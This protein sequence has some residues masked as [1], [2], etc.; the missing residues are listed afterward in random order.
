M[1]DPASN[2]FATEPNSSS[3]PSS[4]LQ[5]SRTN[6]HASSTSPG[7][8]TANPRTQSSLS[9]GSV[10][11]S[12]PPPT[13]RA[14]FPDPAKEP[15]RGSSRLSGP[16]P[17]EDFC[18]DRD[19]QISGGDEISIVDAFK[20]TEGGKTSYIT[21]VIR[22]GSST[23]RRRYSQFLSLHQALQGLYPVLIIPPIPS[24]QSIT[25][26]AVKGQSK[27]KE[28]ATT[29]SKRKRLLE[30][31]LRRLARHPILGGDH[32][33]HRFLDDSAS[34]SEV[35]HSPPVSLLPKNPLH[36]PS[37]NPTFTPGPEEDS[38]S[39]STAYIAHHLLPTPSPNHP[40]QRPDQRF[41]ESEIFTD[42]FQQH[43]GGTMEKVNR[44]VVKR[45]GEHASD[46][47]ELGAQWNEFSL[48]QTGPL[49]D[50]IE[51]VGQAVDKDYEG[52]TDLI[53]SWETHATEPLHTY[54]QFGQLIRQRLS[55]RHQKHVQY[56][57]VQEA[58]ENQRDKLELLEAAERE[59]R[60]LEEALD[61]GSRIIDPNSA[62]TTP[63]KNPDQAAEETSPRPTPRR[64]AQSFGLLS[65]VKHSLSGMMDVDPEA[66]RR[67][68]IG[69]TRDN[70]SQLEDSLQ[71]S[72][73]DLKYASTTLQADLDRFQRQKVADLRQLGIQLATI[74]R[75]W[76][77]QN[78]EAWKA[79]QEAIRAIPDHPNYAPPAPTAQAS[80]SGSASGSKID[81]AS[82]DRDLPPVPKPES[83]SSPF[84]SVPVQPLNLGSPTKPRS[85]SIDA[86]PT[87]PIKVASSVNPTSPIKAA[88]PTN[89][90]SPSATTT[91]PSAT[92]PP[93]ISTEA[94]DASKDEGAGPLGPL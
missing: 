51:K 86:K 21:Y 29:I 68:S 20:T 76:C 54:A 31:F 33:F 47:A 28:D 85:S 80:G 22:L 14:S 4:P 40:L 81:L 71:A 63:T 18:C 12:S 34:W 74:H 43:F 42:K 57:L 41:L 73:Q 1:E 15:K 94:K 69:R 52:T 10:A 3:A 27:T 30:D 70:I 82:L 39:T 9:V 44:R 65:A 67:A 90:L 17:K 19:R 46:M 91:L 61:R 26:Y 72:A 55:F 77:R 35:L 25:D 53:N 56:E 8:A 75:E 59:S 50:A 84:S 93:S 87:S 37:H 16:K 49:G 79:A 5:L 2:P 6:S 89:P 45:W 24:K 62:P 11:S 7:N 38:A 58:L 66:T 92:V 23:V 13:Q 60:R 32:V 78:L 64:A 36:A 83:P 88:S 48:A